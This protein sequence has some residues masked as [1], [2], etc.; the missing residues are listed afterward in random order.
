MILFVKYLCHQVLLEAFCE[1]AASVFL[2]HQSKELVT[3]IE[4]S[5]KMASLGRLIAGISHE[6]RNPLTVIERRTDQLWE[7]I[8]DLKTF[9]DLQ[10]AKQQNPRLLSDVESEMKDL[11]ASIS[12]IKKTV[13]S[14][15][16]FS[17]PGR[18]EFETVDLHQ[19]IESSL[20]LLWNQIKFKADVRR[21]FDMSIPR[22]ECSPQ[23][24]QHVFV[25]LLL[26]ALD[27]IRGSG[28][29]RIET[30]KEDESVIVKVA[31]SGKG[32]PDEIKDRIF[33]PFFTT[34]EVGKGSGLGLSIV[35]D[36]I[37][38]HTG[39]ID[40]SRDKNETVFTIRLPV[41]QK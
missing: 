9:T 1:K 20:K 36:L 27:A 5:E 38:H 39:E 14:L 16:L 8:Q 40:V 23:K 7:D 13:D 30:R 33:V 4:R 35:Y 19:I 32:L 3:Q 22:I 10:K 28:Y 17:H 18:E 21:E 41:K 2:M 24:L 34:K 12:E 31:D 37:R 15:Y 6:I 25:N 11:K 26:N 29:I